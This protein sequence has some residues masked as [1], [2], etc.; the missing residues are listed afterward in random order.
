MAAPVRAKRPCS[1]LDEG[2]TRRHAC[3]LTTLCDER[4]LSV[5]EDEG[6]R[7]PVGRPSTLA[8]DTQWRVKAPPPPHPQA[9]AT[10]PVPRPP[11]A[12]S[13]TCTCSSHSSASLSP[14]TDCCAAT[15]P[16]ADAARVQ[17]GPHAAPARRTPNPPASGTAPGA[18]QSA[19]SPEGPS[20]AQGRAGRRRTWAGHGVPLRGMGGGGE[21]GPGLLR[22]SPPPV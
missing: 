5:A 15:V 4:G 18:S 9:V 19:D 2:Y 13:G 6:R 21:W 14:I 16:C 20:R 17:R 11:P 3:P 12:V 8:M 7:M 22:Q 1:S 10:G